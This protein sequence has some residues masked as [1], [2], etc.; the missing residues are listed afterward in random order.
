MEREWIIKRNNLCTWEVCINNQV[1]AAAK[2]AIGSQE[3]A[4]YVRLQVE[5]HFRRKGIGTKLLNIIIDDLRTEDVKVL[6]AVVQVGSEG[7]YFALNT[8]A[9]VGDELEMSVLNRDALDFKMLT[10]YALLAPDYRFHCWSAAVPEEYVDS[11]A[12]AKRFI[13]DA[14]NRFPPSVPLW[15]KELIRNNE[16][17]R[18]ASGKMLWIGALEDKRNKEIIAFSEIEVTDEEEASQEDTVVLPGYRRK[19]LA[20]AVKANLIAELLIKCPL[21]IH[22]T[23]TTALKNIGMRTVNQQLG[24]QVE[25]KRNLMRLSMD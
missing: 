9:E 8:G 21:V 14:P 12:R 24:F 1:V 20:R 19:G 6:E 23:V 11:Y 22:I 10:S 2:I 17:H 3:N 15:D 4:R 16:K 18:Q 25:I 5:P 7:E 13:S